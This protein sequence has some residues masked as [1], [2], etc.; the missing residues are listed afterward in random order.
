MTI[1][2]QKKAAVRRIRTLFR[3]REEYEVIGYLSESRELTDELEAIINSIQL[4]TQ[5]VR[6]PHHPSRTVF[7]SLPAETNLRAR[8][9]VLCPQ[10]QKEAE[11]SLKAFREAIESQGAALKELEALMV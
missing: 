8:I 5:Q 2:Q 6:C 4:K 7:D 1:E 11:S 3:S 10:C 9:N